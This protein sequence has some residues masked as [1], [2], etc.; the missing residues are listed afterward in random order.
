MQT[1]LLALAV[2]SLA[3]CSTSPG[4]LDR[5][6]S[7]DPDRS[8]VPTEHPYE[9]KGTVKTVSGEGLLGMEPDT[10]TIA[11]DGAPVARLHVA[12]KTQITLEDRRARLSDLR[13]GD[14][15]RAYFDFDRDRPVAIQIVAEPR[16]R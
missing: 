15:V 5:S 11:R 16:R 2:F 14:E 10:I 4:K 6:A 8:P 12:D 3:A 9:M 1:R 7:A 13:E